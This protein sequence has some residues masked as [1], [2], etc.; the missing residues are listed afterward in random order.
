MLILFSIS[1][2]TLQTVLGVL[3]C[4][5]CPAASVATIASGGAGAAIAVKSCV[6]CA[7]DAASRKRR[8]ADVEAE[9]DAEPDIDFDVDV[10]AE[11]E[12]AR[13][14]KTIMAAADK[15]GD[16][17]LDLTEV[18]EYLAIHLKLDIQVKHLTLHNNNK[19]N[20]SKLNFLKSN[21]SSYNG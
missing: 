13:T 17:V 21:C 19:Y 3:S 9:F 14:G 15:N 2:S 1:Q 6:R 11:V 12:V 5:G 18:S 20:V 10:D 7:I 4:I 16:G 8:H